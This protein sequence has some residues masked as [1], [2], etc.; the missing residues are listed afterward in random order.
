MNAKKNISAANKLYRG[1][2]N[3]IDIILLPLQIA[4]LKS[5]PSIKKKFKE[6][7]KSKKSYKKQFK[8]ILR[9]YKKIQQIKKLKKLNLAESYNI[10]TYII[11]ILIFSWISLNTFMF[12]KT[13]WE[14]LNK[15]V[16]FQ[17]GVIEKAAS[18]LISAADNYLNYVGDKLLALENI[19]NNKTISGLIKRTANRD[20]LQRNV[21]SWMRIS[22]V[23]NNN[24]VAITSDK[25]QL[26]QPM[27]PQKYYPLN[28]ALDNET[29]RLR[30]GNVTHIET[31]ITS[32]KMLPIAMRID[33]DAFE[34]I[35]TFIS[36]IPLE[37]IQRQIDWVFGDADICYI[38]VDDN[39]DLLSKSNNLEHNQYDAQRIRSN[40][41]V[42]NYILSFGQTLPEIDKFKIRMGNCIF[43]HLEKSPEYKINTLT[44]YHQKKAWK[45]LFFQLL[46]TIG[47]SIGVA[48]FFMFT[49][50]FFRKVKITPFVN[51][52]ISAKEG[53]EQA[54][55]AKSQ[56]LSNMS[57]E[58]RT[59]M[60]GIIGMSQALVESGQ[61]K[62]DELDQANTIYRSA[63]SLLIIL[64]DILNFSKIEAKKI[65]I[66]NITFNIRD[67]VEDV[68]DLMSA[69]A[70]NKGIEIIT[71]IDKKIPQNLIC[72]MG[73]I[74]QIINN[75]VNNAIKFT[76]YGHVLIDVKL[77][78]KNKDQYLINFNIID[79]GIGIPKEKL[80]SLFK[81][82]T[83]V[84]MSTTRKYG[85]TGLGLSI[86]K[87][88]VELMKGKISIES[89]V[90]KGSNFYFNIPMKKAAEEEADN[91]E[92]Q[93]KQI[94]NKNIITIENNQILTEK[95]D[96]KLKTLKLNNKFINKQN[97]ADQLI[98]ILKI[99][100]N[101]KIDA[102]LISHNINNNVNSIEIAKK[103]KENPKTKNIPLI[104]LMSVH[105]KLK[106]GAEN[107]KIFDRVV[108]KPI[109]HLK[110][111]LALFFVFKVTYYE[112]GGE[113]VKAGKIA[114]KEEAKTDNAKSNL[115][116][117]ICE[118]NEVNMKV[119][120]T[121]LKRFNFDLD[122]AENGQEGLNKATH[123]DYDLI[124]MDC[125]MPIMDG[126][127]ATKK[128][129]NLEKEK[130]RRKPSIIFALTANA[131]EDD[132]KK[133]LASGMD[134]F[135]SKPIKKEPI[136]E[137]VKKWFN[138]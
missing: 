48:L 30:V 59:P 118:D 65:D 16:T 114:K 130:Q 33:S 132:K 21:S 1:I 101:S 61:L 83:Q 106:I 68:A 14:S 69:A 93:Q 92:E 127:E 7:D 28:E 24:Q 84:D 119:A 32:Y 45:N 129:R 86:C 128:I 100:E 64:N 15:Q 105:D 99:T 40:L 5:K 11:F 46:V 52:L 102:I 107:M 135:L 72:D 60:N 23:D 56:F 111:K 39:F 18:S 110:L 47:Q 80:N 37:V 43:N 17:G 22:F 6:K 112:E 38:V 117:L 81:E 70:N 122:M 104:C 95:I 34:P 109:K 4:F 35:G 13:F 103:L 57:H 116:V 58:L 131:G 125:M 53:A 27:A 98:D 55:V 97:Q 89:E 136:A 74:R 3:I 90:G 66:E 123:I 126:F 113:L 42:N 115:K 124:L 76:Y 78:E 54:S 31:D 20:A 8:K 88:L 10:F 12:Q 71:D 63:D 62:D 44:G 94:A 50:Y 26:E 9:R 36:Q 108:Q 41:I 79:S 77:L 2:K 96:K 138:N 137:L 87:Q 85:G 25:G 91:Y 49:I 120:Q 75:L 19:D 134:D 73:R 82:F 51:E 67:L 29:W 121:I 133:C